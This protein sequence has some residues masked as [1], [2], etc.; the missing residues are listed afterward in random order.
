MKV[1]LLTIAGIVFAYSA[2]AASSDTTPPAM[3]QAP[4]TDGGI[5]TGVGTVPGA[6]P[7]P[8]Q[9]STTAPNGDTMKSGGINS[10]PASSLP[11]TGTIPR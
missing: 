1:V 6:I 3:I 2:F 10:G 5:N 8:Q 4:S 9:P 7:D 11:D